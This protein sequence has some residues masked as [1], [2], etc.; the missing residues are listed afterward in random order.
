MKAGAST[1][2]GLNVESAWL[3]IKDMGE[4]MVIGA[5]VIP[6]PLLAVL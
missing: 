1:L 4:Q 2:A 3:P 6:G 5:L